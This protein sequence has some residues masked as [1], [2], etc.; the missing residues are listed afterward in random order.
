MTI[1]NGWTYDLSYLRENIQLEA[2]SR[3]LDRFQDITQ[4]RTGNLEIQQQNKA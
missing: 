1:V 4:H 2:R 3:Q